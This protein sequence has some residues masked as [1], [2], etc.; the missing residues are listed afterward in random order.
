MTPSEA[1]EKHHRQ[2]RAA[3]W[4]YGHKCGWRVEYEELEAQGFLIFM[5]ALE[6]WQPSRG[7]FSTFLT[8][9]L[10]TLK[11]FCEKEISALFISTEEDVNVGVFDRGGFGKYGEISVEENGRGALVPQSREFDR[12]LL[13]LQ[14]LESRA[15]LSK[16]AL[17]LLELIESGDMVEEGRRLFKHQAVSFA[18]EMLGWPETRTRRTWAEIRNWFFAEFAV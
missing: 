11:D 7:S 12:F 16:D 1:F 10:R 8:H 4:K 3:A 18:R 14:A 9:R 6:R 2:V 17:V 5:E 13:S 15:L